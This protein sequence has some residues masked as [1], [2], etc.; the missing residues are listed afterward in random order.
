[1]HAERLPRPTRSSRWASVAGTALLTLANA[2]VKIDPGAETADAAA[3][4]VPAAGDA[5][6]SADAG[7]GCATDSALGLT[8]C[9]ELTACPGVAVD[10][11]VF[12]DCGFRPRSDTVDL[13]CVCNET[14]ICPMGVALGCDQA[15]AALRDGSEANVCAQIADGRCTQAQPSTAPSSSSTSSCDETCRTSCGADV[16]CLALCGC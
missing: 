9:T 14:W 16:T 3:A 5:G 12:P 2:C 10:H 11:G 7:S 13:L 4:Q 15:A 1:M 6:S 8:L